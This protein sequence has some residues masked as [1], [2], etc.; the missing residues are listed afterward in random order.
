MTDTTEGNLPAI[1]NITCEMLAIDTFTAKHQSRYFD[2]RYISRAICLLCIGKIDKC[3]AV[4]F[5]AH[6]RMYAIHQSIIDI[7]HLRAD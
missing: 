4:S 3:C 5:T 6:H 1:G 7:G 2:S